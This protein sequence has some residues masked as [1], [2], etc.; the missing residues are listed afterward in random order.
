MTSGSSALSAA[1][2]LGGG[3]LSA[4]SPFASPFATTSFL[5]SVVRFVTAFFMPVAVDFGGAVLGGAALAVIRLLARSLL[6]LSSGARGAG[7]GAL[8]LQII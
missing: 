3:L 4:A 1:G 8:G 2:G 7:F 6:C 5:A